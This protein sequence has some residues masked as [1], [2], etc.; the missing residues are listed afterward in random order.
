MFRDAFKRKRCLIPASRYYEWHAT[1]SGKQPYYYTAR[2]GDNYLET[3]LHR[4]KLDGTGDVRLTDPALMHT[5]SL[6]PLAAPAPRCEI[7]SDHVR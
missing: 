2:D 3:Q 7:A 1:P 6:S 4:V 5:V